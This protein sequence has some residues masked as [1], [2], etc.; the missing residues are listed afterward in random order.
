M[1]QM[2]GKQMVA[3]QVIAAACPS[4]AKMLTDAVKTEELEGR[5]EVLG[6]AE[7]VS[8]ARVR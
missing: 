2:Q 1:T 5:L 6:M 7:I 4:C 8:R 3:A